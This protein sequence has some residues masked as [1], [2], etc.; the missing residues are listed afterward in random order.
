[1]NRVVV[2]MK[3]LMPLVEERL[4]A[5]QEAA[6]TVKGTSMRPFFIDGKTT[7]TLSSPSFPIRKYAVI[8]YETGSGAIVLHRVVGRKGKYYRTEGDGLRSC[9]LVAERSVK[10]VVTAHE[11]D[12][13]KTEADDPKYLRRVRLW[14]F[15]RPIR[16]LLLGIARRLKRWNG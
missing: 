1:M 3:D 14:R 12:G 4:A 5:G 10:A 2:S 16:Y 11:T 8:L 7:V 6:I 13:K 15:L 9:E